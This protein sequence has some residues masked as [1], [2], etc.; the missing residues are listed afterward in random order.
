MVVL[1]RRSAMPQAA[2]EGGRESLRLVGGSNILRV[3]S[4]ANDPGSSARA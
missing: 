4:S 1:L 3:N 2:A